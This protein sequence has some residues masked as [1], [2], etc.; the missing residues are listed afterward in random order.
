MKVA[1]LAPAGALAASV[2]RCLQENGHHVQAVHYWPGSARGEKNG[3]SN[4]QAIRIREA[5]R[6]ARVVLHLAWADTETEPLP[7]HV[8]RCLLPLSYLLS[9]ACELPSKI[10]RVVVVSPA[11]L[12]GEGS[13]TCP[14]NGTVTP[15]WRREEDLRAHRWEHCCPV[16]GEQLL[17]AP[18]AETHPAAPLSGSGALVYAQER[19]VTSWA[20]ERRIPVVALRYFEA[21]GA[22]PK[23][24]LGRWFTRAAEGRP[25]DV[26]ED[27][28][29]TRD[30]IHVDDVARAVP[31]AVR[32]P[33]SE[34]L[35]LNVASGIQTSVL[36]LL[37]CLEQAL[38][39]PLRVRC[40][41]SFIRSEARHLYAQTSEIS[42]LGYRPPISLREGLEQS[43]GTWLEAGP[44]LSQGRKL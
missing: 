33:G 42:R 2:M 14:V 13:Y 29:Q 21:Y 22:E 25:L 43:L 34:S 20:L 30:F 36:E 24:A 3:F 7:P 18:T 8:R 12:Y 5:L 28:R 1:M 26:T 16:C 40:S 27:G 9:A 23:G 38:D 37:A 15:Q 39:K 32:A 11:I 44:K 17:P 4:G 19:L 41:A 35:V 10:E 31:L 6:G